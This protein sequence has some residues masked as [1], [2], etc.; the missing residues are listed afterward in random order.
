MPTDSTHAESKQPSPIPGERRRSRLRVLGYLLVLSTVGSTWLLHGASAEVSEAAL[1][2]GRR[3]QVLGDT[4]GDATRLRINGQGFE[5]TSL[6]SQKSLPDLMG[7]F[8]ALCPEPIGDLRTALSEPFA[9]Q[10]KASH[11]PAELSVFSFRYSA[12]EQA[13]FCFGGIEDL[14]QLATRAARFAESG[15]LTDIGPV[16]YLYASRREG[17][18]F[19]L[20]LTSE[21]RLPLF[22]MF[23]GAGDAPGED[24]IPGARPPGSRRVFSVEAHGYAMS[25]YE[26][27]LPLADALA[28]YALALD[29]AGLSLEELPGPA[30]GTPE[31]TVRLIRGPDALYVLSAYREDER[32]LLSALRLGA[33]EDLTTRGAPRSAFE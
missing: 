17:H 16:R 32:A 7:H 1:G 21:D 20:L 23:P 15:D 14:T 28:R 9:R 31:H 6:R 25:T 3:L 33:T 4:V 10:P 8:A 26:S 2:L 5:L 24:V 11:N 22:E 18:T 29:R 13:M 19:A 30:P 27:P 12:A